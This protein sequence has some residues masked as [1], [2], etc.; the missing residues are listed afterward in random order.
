MDEH[1]PV[2]I[3]AVLNALAPEADGF[4]VDATYGRGGHTARLLE[5]LGPRGAVL[6]LDR[7]PQAVRQG[8]RRFGHDRRFAIVHAAFADLGTV[9]ARHALGREV[10][11]VLFDLGV[12]SPQLDTPARGFSFTRDGPLDMRMDPSRGQPVS[13]WLAQASVA[14]LRRVIAAYGEERFA[15]RV[16]AA[17]DAAR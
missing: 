6:A 12:S 16:A 8:E 3:D 10:R 17:I 5:S 7:D 2:L 11:G 15:R 1:E 14:E 9:L 13:A 4:Y